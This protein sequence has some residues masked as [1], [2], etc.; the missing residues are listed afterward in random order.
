MNLDIHQVLPLLAKIDPGLT[1]EFLLSSSIPLIV[2][3]SGLISTF[4][5]Y[6][7][8]FPLS[9]AILPIYNTI[10]AWKSG[11]VLSTPVLLYN[12]TMM[13]HGI[14]LSLY[15]YY[16]K[17]KTFL[18][19]F[20]THIVETS[21]AYTALR[22]ASLLVRIINWLAI[23]GVMT[24]WNA[25]PYIYTLRGDGSSPTG[26]L[27]LSLIALGSVLQ[28]TADHQK[29]RHKY[30]HGPYSYCKD[31]VYKLCRHPNYLGEI[32]YHL[33]VLISGYSLF[34]SISR[35]LL[36]GIIPLCFVPMMFFVTYDMSEKQA[37]KYERES[38]YKDYQASVK[39]LIP[40][41][42]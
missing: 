6:E 26:V 25:I 18:E 5:V 42:W 1:K 30:I 10:S 36:V 17:N 37:A 39:R 34:P 8:G 38:T 12:S 29:K 9:F 21:N 41:V 40:Y 28:A 20:N 32:L 14:I 23:T 4:N 22:D 15:M 3:S 2:C 7:H 35:W 11:T 13:F 19:H 31:G 27:G 24:C 33:G 16:R